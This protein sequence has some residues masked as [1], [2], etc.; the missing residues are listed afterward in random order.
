MSN[1]SKN[2]VSLNINIMQDRDIEYMIKDV[3]QDPN[4]KVHLMSRLIAS[5]RSQ[6]SKLTVK[7]NDL[8]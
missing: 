2:G 5:L 1:Y 7:Y 4:T 8:K 6:L 3:N